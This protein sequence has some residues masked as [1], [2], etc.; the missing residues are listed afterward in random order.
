MKKKM[1]FRLFDYCK[2]LSSKKG[3][4]YISNITKFFTKMISYYSF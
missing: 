4:Y 2:E 1:D 3:N